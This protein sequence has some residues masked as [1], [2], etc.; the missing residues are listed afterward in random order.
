LSDPSRQG[1]LARPRSLV[2]AKRVLDLAI[3]KAALSSS[4]AASD[5]AKVSL[6]QQLPSI[7]HDIKSLR[8]TYLEK[9]RRS[10]DVDLPDG[11]VKMI[12]HSLDSGNIHPDI[13]S[14]AFDHVMEGV[15]QN[16]FARFVSHV[17]SGDSSLYS[18]EPH[19]LS[20]AA[21]SRMD[22]PATSAG[23]SRRPSTVMNVPKQSQ[24][25]TLARSTELAIIQLHS[26]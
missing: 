24:S 21:G 13:F 14:R 26:M 11:M 25:N 12:L 10:K 1:G 18:S 6:L 15:K 16:G 8:D 23:T 3:L 4:E 9:E 7:E 22:S 5:P 20:E 19:L 2:R 17:E